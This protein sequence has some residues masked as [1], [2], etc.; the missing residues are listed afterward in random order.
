MPADAI[1]PESPTG[2]IGWS[3][4]L[5]RFGANP[6]FIEKLARTALASQ[7]KVVGQ[8]REKAMQLDLPGV[9]FAAHG[10]KSVA[11]YFEASRLFE[12]ARR[13]ESAARGGDEEAFALAAELAA[14]FDALLAELKQR[15]PE[16]D[17]AP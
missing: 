14:G 15:F 10:L 7:P 5:N 1:D 2:L 16:A 13:T 12:L 9:G 3:K 8:L 4:L 11:G 17:P 6:G